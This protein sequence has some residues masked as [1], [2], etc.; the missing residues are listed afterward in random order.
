MSLV[1]DEGDDTDWRFWFL[2]RNLL[3]RPRCIVFCDPEIYK[4]PAE[5][6]A[7]VYYSD[8]L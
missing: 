7:E 2:R 4:M 1:G 5:S 8:F 3:T 6:L